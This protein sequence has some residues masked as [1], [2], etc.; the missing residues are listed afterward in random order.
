MKTR[1]S[2]KVQT[3]KTN[4]ISDEAFGD[5]KAAMV[6]ALAFER[7]KRRDLKVTLIKA[8]RSPKAMSQKDR[9]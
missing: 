3:N 8:L 4:H 6:D 9:E 7:G 1:K 5:L 2:R